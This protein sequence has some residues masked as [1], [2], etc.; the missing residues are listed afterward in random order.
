MEKISQ[1]AIILQFIR[2]VIFAMIV[3]LFATFYS[4]ICVLC[5]PLPLRYRHRVVMGWTT[6]V[7]W[8][9]KVICHVNYRVEG[10]ENI[11]RDRPGI[12]FSKHQSAWETFFLPSQFNETAIIL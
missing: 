11:P 4:L 3:P 8:F 6:T 5:F 10:F 7:V 1:F 12:I 2:S 9:L